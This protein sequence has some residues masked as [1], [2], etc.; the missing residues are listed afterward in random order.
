[1]HVRRL[2]ISCKFVWWIKH[3]D[4]SNQLCYIMILSFRILT[5]KF[6]AS[7]HGFSLFAVLAQIKLC[8]MLCIHVY[9]FHQCLLFSGSFMTVNPIQGVEGDVAVLISPVVDIGEE[10]CLGFDMYL[11]LSKS[12]SEDRLRITLA[13]PQTPTVSSV[14]IR[15]ITTWNNEDWRH[16]NV[17]L[18]QGRYVIRFEYTMGIP[19]RG[20][21]AIDNVHV[22]RCDTETIGAKA[23]DDGGTDPLIPMCTK[24]LINDTY[25]KVAFC[26]KT[27]LLQQK[28]SPC[29]YAFW[30]KYLYA[31]PERNEW[32]SL[33]YVLGSNWQKRP[34]RQY[35]ITCPTWVY[36]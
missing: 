24:R 33:K 23:T 5:A 21:V 17:P 13:V 20:V 14:T 7:W 3:P 1:M 31:F 19:Y 26:I 30:T 25:H 32:S 2:E 34:M 6:P 18:R 22:Q 16:L 4:G 27:F 35:G 12:S 28:W 9:H 36:K 11:V 8:F 29:L 10:M 15:E